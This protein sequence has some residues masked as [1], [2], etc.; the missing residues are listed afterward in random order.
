MIAV[1]CNLVR[2][3]NLSSVHDQGESCPHPI[4]SN[5]LFFLNLRTSKDY[6][7]C[8]CKLSHS[9]HYCHNDPIH[10]SP[11]AIVYP[12]HLTVMTNLGIS[13]YICT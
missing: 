9:G 1:V 10:I 3:K 5:G 8:L 2:R 11:E 12:Y 4:I 7:T 6:V 13:G